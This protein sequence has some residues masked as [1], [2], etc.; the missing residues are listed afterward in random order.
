MILSKRI[1]NRLRIYGGLLM[2]TIELKSLDE[3]GDSLW[4]E[5]ADTKRTFSY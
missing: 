2:D 4:G 3:Y 1:W 5:Y